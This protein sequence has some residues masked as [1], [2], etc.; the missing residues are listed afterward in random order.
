[1]DARIRFSLGI[2]T[3]LA[4][5]PLIVP[6]AAAAEPADP[7]AVIR[8]AQ[9]A[10]DAVAAQSLNAPRASRL[11]AHV[12]VA[13][14]LAVAGASHACS[15]AAGVAATQAAA[16]VAA[17]ITPPESPRFQALAQ[18]EAARVAATGVGEGAIECGRRTGTA[19]GALLALRAGRDGGNQVCVAT[20]PTGPGLWVPTPPA[21]LPA[22]EACAGRWRTWQIPDGSWHRPPPP[23]AV[24]SPAYLAATREVYEVGVNLTDEQRRIADLWAGGPI[25]PA[26]VWVQIA[27]ELLAVHPSS[28]LRA[29]HILAVQAMAQADAFIACWNAKFTYWTER[30]VT[31]IHRLIDPMWRSYLVTP[32]F[33]SYVSGHSTQSAAAAVVLGSFFPAERDRLW[34]Q[35]LEAAESRLYG[36]IHFRFDNENGLRLGSDIGRAALPS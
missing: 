25:T 4:V 31:A 32:P 30:P 14:D 33:P 34:S 20:P 5:G 9:T 35:A 36:G 19:A 27:L 8:V 15:P 18:A 28:Q 7:G 3:A 11:F 26:G 23:P 22:L 12:F 6:T 16:T 2:V 1:M 10:L 29:A 24:E 17:A 21:Y 13:T